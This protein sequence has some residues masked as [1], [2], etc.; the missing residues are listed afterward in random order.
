[1]T[2]QC[3]YVLM[4]TL[5]TKCPKLAKIGLRMHFICCYSFCLG[6]QV[7]RTGEWEIWSLSGRLPDNLGEQ[8]YMYNTGRFTASL[9]A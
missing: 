3:L 5:D 9:P 4:A 1:M 6:D 8:A 7:T 2:S